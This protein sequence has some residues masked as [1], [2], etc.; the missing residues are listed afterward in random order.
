[1]AQISG[2]TDEDAFDTF[3]GEADAGEIGDGAGGEAGAVVE[4]EDAAV[5]ISIGLAP[6]PTVSS[7]SRLSSKRLASKIE[8]NYTLF[9][10]RD[11]LLPLKNDL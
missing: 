3:W 9:F 2:Q 1:M 7:Q 4:P 8:L 11:F 5:A 6:G 10:H